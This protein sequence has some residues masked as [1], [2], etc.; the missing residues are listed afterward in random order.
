MQPAGKSVDPN[1]GG[2]TVLNK[3]HDGGFENADC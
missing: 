3:Y 2:W 1:T